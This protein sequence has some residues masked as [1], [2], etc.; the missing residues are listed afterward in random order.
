MSG[1]GHAA[2]ASAESPSPAGSTA[3]APRSPLPARD[4]PPARRNTTGNESWCREGGEPPFQHLGFRFFPRKSCISP[5][6]LPARRYSGAPGQEAELPPAA[7]AL[8]AFKEPKPGKGTAALGVAMAKS[9]TGSKQSRWLVFSHRWLIWGR[10]SASS[11]SGCGT[12]T[13]PR[14]R[15]VRCSWAVPTASPALSEP[16]A[17]CSPSTF[18]QLFFFPP[19]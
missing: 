11:C 12:A 6:L 17:Q 10:I 14:P 15:G 2:V 1:H 13:V 18:L 9:R 8:S 19:N 7:P 3:P 5:L 4:V 16:F